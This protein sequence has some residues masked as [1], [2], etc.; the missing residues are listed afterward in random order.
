[1]HHV[2]WFVL[3]WIPVVIATYR[4]HR[5]TK[6]VGTVAFVSLYFHWIAWVAVVL[7]ALIGPKRPDA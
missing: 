3:G 2:L 4:G 7:F 5:F 6:I 1:M